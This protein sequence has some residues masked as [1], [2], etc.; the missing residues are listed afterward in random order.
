M[1]E[2]SLR[3]EIELPPFD[4]ANRGLRMAGVTQQMLVQDRVAVVKGI[5]QAIGMRIAVAEGP[6]VRC[7][8]VGLLGDARERAAGG[9][10]CAGDA[11][12]RCLIE[13]SHQVRSRHLV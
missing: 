11:E 8:E 9:E 1:D 5:E 3:D 7:T 10:S 4:V 13:W 6:V 12:R 2:Q